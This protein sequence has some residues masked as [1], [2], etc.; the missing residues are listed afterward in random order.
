MSTARVVDPSIERNDRLVRSI[1][2]IDPRSRCGRGSN[3]ILSRNA[4]GDRGVVREKERRDL[5]VEWW[6]VIAGERFAQAAGS[7]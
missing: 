4:P 6:R 7:T 1:L 5:T 2:S 3:E